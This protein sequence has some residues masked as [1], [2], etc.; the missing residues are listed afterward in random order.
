[1]DVWSTTERRYLFGVWSA[2]VGKS[3]EE[4]SPEPLKYSE[5]RR[6]C[7][8]SKARLED[9]DQSVCCALLSFPTLPRF[10]G[11]LFAEAGDREFGFQC[12]HTSTMI[13]LSRSGAA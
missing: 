13:G 7:T 11:Q 5:M 4:F 10:C 9:M 1:M 2:V 8:D 3:K 6:G 12:L